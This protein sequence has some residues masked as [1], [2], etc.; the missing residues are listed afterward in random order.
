MTGVEA[1]KRELAYEAAAYV[2]RRMTVEQALAALFRAG[3]VSAR[4]LGE[5]GER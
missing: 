1:I 4:E 3:V 2:D 5:D